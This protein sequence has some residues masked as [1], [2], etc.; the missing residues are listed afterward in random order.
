MIEKPIFSIITI[1]YNAGEYITDTMKS[2]NEQV[3]HNFEHIIVDGASSDNTLFIVRQFNNPSTIII[4]EKDNGLYDAMN[5]GLSMARGKYVIF[6]N[7]GDTFASPLTLSLFSEATRNDPDI[8]YGDTI[9]VDKARRFKAPRHLSVPEKL[10]FQSFSHGMLICHQAFCV[11]KSIAP[12]Y[13]L[14]YRFSADYDWTI[15]CIKKSVPEKCINLHA[16]V[17]HYLDDGLTEKNKKASLKERYEIMKKHYG[18]AKAIARHLSFVPRAI[19]RKIKSSGR[20]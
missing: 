3:C 20:K 18:T 6:L 14:S 9:I 12:Q 11:K 1:T 2:V 4:S 13:D 10:T 17:I 5:K 8:I 16:I 15:K 7:A 19:M